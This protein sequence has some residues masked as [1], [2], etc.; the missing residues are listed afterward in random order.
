MNLSTRRSMPGMTAPPTRLRDVVM[1][2]HAR[3]HA[4]HDLKTA[5]A[6]VDFL[7]DGV[8]GAVAKVRARFGPSR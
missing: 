6:I 3:R 8:G 7:F 5:E 1:S 4:E 2:Q